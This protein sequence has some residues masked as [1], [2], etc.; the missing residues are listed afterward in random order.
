MKQMKLNRKLGAIAQMIRAV[1]HR[2]G[3]LVRRR[4]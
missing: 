2:P 3:A 1:G 4:S